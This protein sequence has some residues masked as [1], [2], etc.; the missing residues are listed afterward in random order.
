M[1]YGNGEIRTL[2]V[3]IGGTK[4]EPEKP[5]EGVIIRTIDELN[6]IA[7]PKMKSI[8]IFLLYSPS[9]DLY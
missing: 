8:K 4:W 1:F 9:T 7:D 3:S 6:E 2:P 5:Q